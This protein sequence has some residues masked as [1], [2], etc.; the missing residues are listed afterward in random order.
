[1]RVNDAV[2]GLAFALLGGGLIHQASRLPGFPGQKYGP[3]LFPTILGTGLLIC[4]AGL[5]LRGVRQ[6]ATGGAWGVREDW[7][8]E[9]RPVANVLVIL[10]AIVFYA[11]FSERLGFIPT[12][13]GIFMSLFLWFRVPPVKALLVAAT[14]TWAFHWFFGSLFR[15][16]LP[17]GLLNTIL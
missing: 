14:A 6:L 4:A 12:A 2:S 3:D 7:M 13:F 10:A 15:I 17:R 11:L 5:I 8:R 16:P 9:R 1:M